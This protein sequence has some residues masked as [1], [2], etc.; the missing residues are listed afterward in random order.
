MT[1]EE[2]RRVQA[3]EPPSLHERADG[4]GVGDH[5]S[6]AL[7]VRQHRH[8]AGR[9]DL[10]TGLDDDFEGVGDRQPRSRKLDQHALRACEHEL[11]RA[12][13]GDLARVHLPAPPQI[14]PP[15]SDLV[16]HLRERSVEQAVSCRRARERVPGGVR[17]RRREEYPRARVHR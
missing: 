6:A 12:A 14:E 17:V 7:G 15:G 5:G 4:V 3:Q 8:E 16:P 11:G 10:H 2:R 1:A 13:R 9:L